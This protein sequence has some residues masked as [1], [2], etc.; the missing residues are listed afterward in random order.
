M[1]KLKKKDETQPSIEDVMM[2]GQRK[3]TKQRPRRKSLER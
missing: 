2:V 1:G 3:I